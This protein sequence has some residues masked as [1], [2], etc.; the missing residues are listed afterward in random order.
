M[1]REDQYNLVLKQIEA[2]FEGENNLVANLAN[3][4]ALLKESFQFFWVGFYLV[5]G[6]ELVLGPFQGPVACSRISKGKGVC[7]KSWEENKSILVDDVEEF[8]GH[9]ACN[10]N[11][12]SE[13]VVPIRNQSNEVIGVLDVDH[14]QLA[15]FN[16]TDVS[17]LERISELI[18]QN[19]G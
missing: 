3:V 8:P 14:D 15:F 4:S 7:G 10:P 12:K 11:S 1:N 13:I 5:S 9:I 19:N 16:E 17:G 18:K 2:L 6:S